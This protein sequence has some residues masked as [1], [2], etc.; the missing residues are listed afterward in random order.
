MIQRIQSI[1][2]LLAI[3]CMAL[4]FV[5]P[6]ATYRLNDP[7]LSQTTTAQLDLLAKSNPEMLNEIASLEPEVTFSQKDSGFKTWPLILLAGL[8]IAF[9]AFS[10]F[11]FKRRMVQVKIVMVAF[12]INLAYAFVVFF[13][14][15]D[16]YADT[17]KNYMHINDMSVTWNT[18]AFLPLASLLFIFLAQRAIRKDEAKVRAADRLR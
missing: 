9:A 2:L 13:W 5:F 18:G 4:C 6:T 16:K 11:L 10:I 12:M 7:T 15:V 17:V 8:T 3:V 1:W 14:A